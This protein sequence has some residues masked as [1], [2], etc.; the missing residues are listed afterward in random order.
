[1]TDTPVPTRRIKRGW[2]NMRVADVVRETHDTDTFILVDADEGGRVFDY[3]AGQY[4]T[5]RFDDI[6]EKPIVRSYTMSSSPCQPDYS[7]FTVKRV[8][9]GVISNW[10]C[11]TIKPDMILRARGPIGKFC[12]DP[13]KDQPHLVM[14]AGGSGVTPFVSILREYATR[15]GTPGA[16]ERMTLL[17]SYRTREDLICWKELTQAAAVPGVKVFTTLSREDKTREGFWYGRLTDDMIKR[18]VDGRYD[19]TT[20]MTCGPDAI[21]DLTVAHLRAQGVEESCIKT[22]SFAS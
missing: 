8:E 21:M 11:N 16:P 12:Y 14:V 6:A 7:A 5:F 13:A 1:M 15:L 9:G 19:R 4:L 3:V 10:L 2:M 18:A 17:V 20:Y 22:E